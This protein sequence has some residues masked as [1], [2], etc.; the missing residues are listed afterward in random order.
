MSISL[1]A[2]VM[3]ATAFVLLFL[4][5]KTRKRWVRSVDIVAMI[6]LVVGAVAFGGI[7]YSG[8]PEV[9]LVSCNTVANAASVVRACP[10]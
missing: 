3:L 2:I 6:V 9:R 4:L 5:P 1:C 10:F 7:G 8:R